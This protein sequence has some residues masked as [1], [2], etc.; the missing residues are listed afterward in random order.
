MARHDTS[1]A[2]L[3]VPAPRFALGWAALVYSLSVL[4][5]GYHAL[6]GQFLVWAGSD[7]YKAG[8]AFREFAA[9]SLKSGQGFP[10]WNPY[11]QGGVPYVAAMSGDIFYPTFILRMILPTDVA[12]TWGF[13]IHLFLAGIFTY[14]F[15]RRWGLG[16]FPSLAG[17]AAYLMSGALAG[18][19]SPGHDGKLFISA[20]LPLTLWAVLR[21]VRDGK[22]WAF[23]VLAFVI[24]LDV[25]TPHPQLLQYLL[26]LA[27]AF[28]LF[29]AFGRLDGERALPRVVAIRRLAFA[30]GAVVLGGLIGAI[31]FVP[32]RAFVAWSQRAG[33]REYEFATQFSMPPEELINSYLPQFSGIID[34][35]WG[36]NQFHLHSDYVGAVVLV[37]LGAA[38]LTR[39]HRSLMWFFAGTGVVSLLWALGGFTPFYLIIYHLVP[40]TKFFRAPSTMLFIVSFSASV[41]A[42]LGVER[43]LSREVGRR[44]L[45]GWGV[46]AVVITVLALSGGLTAVADTVAFPEKYEAIRANAPAVTVGA[47]R[48]LLFVVL[49][50]G[51]LLGV[52]EEKISPRAFGWAITVLVIADLWTVEKYY[53]KFSAPASTLYATN[54]AVEYVKAQPEPGRVLALPPSN[55]RSDHGDA[56]LGRNALMLHRVRSVAGYHGNEIGRYLQLEGEGQGNLLSPRF[57]RLTNTRYL[58]TDLDSIPA[59]GFKRL[60]GPVKDASGNLIS[61]FAVPGDNPAA[62]VTPV[63]VKAPDASVLAAIYDPRFEPAS[64]ALFDTSAKVPSKS[65]TAL[66]APLSITTS[67]KYVSPSHIRVQLSAP[68]PDGA[69]LVV[70]EN[71]YPGWTALVDGKPA[72]ADRADLS[73]I[74][75]VL[76]AGGR[77][78]DL[79]FHDTS[80]DTGKTITLVALVASLVWIAAGMVAERKKDG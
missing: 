52:T 4:A 2:A 20:L 23:G 32:V 8:F 10:L 38:F 9:A 71:Y 47:I 69:A 31:Q 17:G 40:G 13:L 46:A 61:L 70:A 58:L 11:L 45:V 18:L 3:D 72:A 5:L 54:A 7:Q 73:L 65:I 78:V 68:A 53:F 26:L 66:P 24:G 80:Y 12:M 25:L 63:I 76:P 59:P 77:T 74:G 51:L 41:L 56:F 28:A 42:A 75:V 27:G 35:Y 79:T 1:R 50:C 67:T 44:Y 64:V 43:A 57:W 34:A 16:F 21:G 55:P 15:L 22:Q 36:R 19:V 37:L 60:V 62:W 48:S 29:V 6:A 39:R 30:A 14:A 33:G 49:A